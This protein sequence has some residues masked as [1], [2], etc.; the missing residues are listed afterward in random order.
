[1]ARRPEVVTL[2]EVLRSKYGVTYVPYGTSD[3]EENGTGFRIIDIPVTFSVV[4]AEGHGEYD[5]QIE[6]YPPRDY[7]YTDVVGLDALMELI[8]KY[9]SPIGVWPT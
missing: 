2:I 6:S 4:L 1:M 9:R 7:I 3:E 5:I 8:E